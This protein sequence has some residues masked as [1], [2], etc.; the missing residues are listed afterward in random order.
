MT[1]MLTRYL[2]A[3]DECEIMLVSSLLSKNLNECYYWLYELYY[4]GYDLK[5]LF[6]KIY[7]DFYFYNSPKLEI[8]IRKKLNKNITIN[9]YNHILQNLINRKINSNIFIM[10]QYIYY[11]INNKPTS[12]HNIKG[13]KPNYCNNVDKK[14]QNLI[15]CIKKNN[16]EGICYYIYK[17]FIIDKCSKLELFINLLTYLNTYNK[18]SI[19]NQQYYETIY[20]KYWTINSNKELPEYYIFIILIVN[21]ITIH[22]NTDLPIELFDNTLHFIESHESKNVNRI[23][24]TLKEKRIFNI[25]PYVGSFKLARFNIDDLQKKMLENWEYY[26]KVTPCWEERHK[27]FKTSFNENNKIIFENDDLLEEFYELYG[28]ELDEQ[29]KEIQNQSIGIINSISWNIWH[30]LYFDE[31]CMC[32]PNNIKLI[33]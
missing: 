16:Y 27:I 13:R 1:Y 15:I 9:T 10:R 24:N 11:L 6:W 7:Y 26:T 21:I 18:N 29:S 12:R 28:Y 25:K 23:Y 32:L 4:S 22:F 14:Y 5:V 33:Y 17:L 20:N 3:R 30:D 31:S 2:Y 8:F 19:Y